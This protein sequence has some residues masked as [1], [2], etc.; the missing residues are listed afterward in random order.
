MYVPKHFAED[1]PGA[2]L[3]LIRAAPFATLLTS[4]GPGAPF[5]THLPLVVEEGGGEA[6]WRLIGHMARANSHWQAFTTGN[7]ST[8]I[9]HGPHAY[10][11]PPGIRTL[12]EAFQPGTTPSCTSAAGRVL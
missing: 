6:N 8:A 11:S 7:V 4:G 5:V 2:Q 12:T 10:V 3:Q 9:F 1:D